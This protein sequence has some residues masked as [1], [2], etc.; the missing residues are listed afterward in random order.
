MTDDCYTQSYFD[1]KQPRGILSPIHRALIS[2]ILQRCNDRSSIL[3]M[4]CAKGALLASL[5]AHF[6]ELVGVDVSPYAIAESR[7]HTAK[8]KTYCC[9]IESEEE[10]ARL[11]GEYR[12]FPVIVSSHTFEHLE[13]PGAVLRRCFNLLK[14]DGYFFLVVPNPNSLLVRL[15]GLLG[16]K[17]RC[18]VYADK[19]H[20]C[21]LPR[22]GWEKLLSQ[23]GF[24]WEFRGTPFFITNSRLLNKVYPFHYSSFL[25]ETG[26][27]LLFICQKKLA[28]NDTSG[29][30]KD[31]L[32][33]K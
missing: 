17:H 11:V 27:E 6:D 25:A 23:A 19:S 1:G 9:N 4:G 33:H 32:V 2:V 26:F 14:D 5:E 3:E 18:K 24:T 10:L 15:Y 8:A 12:E 31:T 22:E 13:N 7:K 28:T 20:K 16:K 29:Q 30:S 21:V